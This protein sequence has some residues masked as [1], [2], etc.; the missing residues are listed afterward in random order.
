MGELSENYLQTF[1]KKKKKESFERA[2]K[3][4]LKDKDFLP[5]K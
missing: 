2:S 3:F 4:F 5:E 1:Q